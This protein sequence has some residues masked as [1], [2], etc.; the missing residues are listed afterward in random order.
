MGRSIDCHGAQLWNGRQ[1]MTKEWKLYK[2][3]QH[4]DEWIQDALMS[5]ENLYLCFFCPVKEADGSS[6]TTTKENPY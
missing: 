3:H 6:F 1:H 4:G 2:I 5:L